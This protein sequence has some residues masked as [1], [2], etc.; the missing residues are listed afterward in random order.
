M[1]GSGNVNVC[2][3]DVHLPVNNETASLQ[4]TTITKQITEDFDTSN[5]FL[6]NIFK[7]DDLPLGGS[8]GAAGLWR[9]GLLR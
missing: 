9:T 6:K 2:S 8:D 1:N 3:G 7:F 4:N 5:N